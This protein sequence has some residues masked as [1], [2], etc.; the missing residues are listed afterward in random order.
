MPN[1][2]PSTNV[3]IEFIGKTGDIIVTVNGVAVRYTQVTSTAIAA[4]K[5]ALELGAEMADGSIFAGL[6][7][8]TKQ[9]IFTMP[10]DLSVPMIFND[11]AKAVK[12]LNTDKTL[13]H[14]DWQ[15]PSL[16]NLRVLQKNQNEG[17]LRGSFN[18][19]NKGNGSTWPGSYWSHTSAT[20]GSGDVRTIRFSDG[21]E[22]DDRTYINRLCC[23]PIRFG[24]PKFS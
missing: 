6:D 11:A 12:K 8:D 18:T 3:D 9:R 10:F 5:D 16:K 14:N 1:Q 17:K 19:T 4:A 2:A 22:G 15:I 20:D 13:G 23:R 24:A 21:F 7:L